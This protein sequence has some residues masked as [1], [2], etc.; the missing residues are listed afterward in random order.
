M[1]G[2]GVYYADFISFYSPTQL[3]GGETTKSNS[4]ELPIAVPLSFLILTP[5]DLNLESALTTILSAGAKVKIQFL[6]TRKRQG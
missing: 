3:C 1:V 4:N 2:V 5:L 6:L